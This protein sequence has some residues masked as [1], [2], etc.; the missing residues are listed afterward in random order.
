MSARDPYI[1]TRF[2]YTAVYSVPRRTSPHKL[3]YR[4]SSPRSKSIDQSIIT[5]SK[6]YISTPSSSNPQRFS[7]Q[8]TFHSTFA[9]LSNPS[10]PLAMDI[11]SFCLGWR[12]VQVCCDSSSASHDP[13]PWLA[14]RSPAIPA[15]Q[16]KGDS[17][18]SPP[19][20]LAHKYSRSLVSSTVT[21]V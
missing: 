15:P 20:I 14:A 18:Q 3:P 17:S 12:K 6:L 2:L 10:H 16:K 19:L 7:F 21:D 9:L 5:G 4:K 1:G 8:L 11:R 13:H